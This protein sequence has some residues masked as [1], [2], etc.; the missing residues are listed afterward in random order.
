MMLWTATQR[1]V[2]AMKMGAVEAPRFGGANDADNWQSVPYRKVALACRHG[3]G[4]GYAKPVPVNF[5][6]LRNPRSG[7]I[8]VA[9][10]VP[11]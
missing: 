4:P 5:R 6:T 7:M 1:H 11:E 2:S 10:L 8:L 9:G 3:S